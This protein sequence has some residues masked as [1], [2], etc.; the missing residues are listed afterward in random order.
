MAGT[1]ARLDDQAVERYSRQ[2]L[3]GEIGERG[4]L[5]LLGGRVVIIGC[6]GLGVAAALYLGGAGVGHLTLVDPD[7]LELDNLNRQV[8]YRTA[9]LGQKKA[10]LLARRVAELNPNIEVR[11]VLERLE[12]PNLASTLGDA[13][14][15]LECSDDPVTKFEVNDFCAARGRSLVVAGAIGFSGQLVT[16][17]PG[18]PCYRCLFGGAP[19]GVANSCREAGIL[20]PVVGVVGAMQALEAVKLLSGLGDDLGGRLLDFD[21]LTARWREV[22]FPKDPGCPAHGGAGSAPG[23][24]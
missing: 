24:N 19:A 13:D 8:A 4:Q 23:D 11:A 16:V 15:V 20:G 9:E 14:V 5:R 7:R 1:P 18:A 22:R 12:A 21:A 10:E 17:P 6:G 2:L 3:L